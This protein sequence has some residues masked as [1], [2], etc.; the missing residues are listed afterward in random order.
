MLN[1]N[2]NNCDTKY[3]PEGILR[4]GNVVMFFRLKLL[5]EFRNNIIPSFIILNYIHIYAKI[6]LTFSIPN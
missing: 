3:I 5:L 2:K 1:V 6:S 4:N